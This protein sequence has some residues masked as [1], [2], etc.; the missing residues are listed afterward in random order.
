MTTS[1]VDP[2]GDGRAP[3][4]ENALVRRLAAQG[5]LVATGQ[6]FDIQLLL[7]PQDPPSRA[8]AAAGAPPGDP[9]M[10][11]AQRFAPTQ[12]QVDQVVAY[13]KQNGFTRIDVDASHFSVRAQGTADNI[14]RAFHV[15]IKTFTYQERR[16]FVNDRTVQVPAYLGALVGSVLGLQNLY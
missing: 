13:L 9:R 1:P 14:A 15:S 8:G 7:K 12:V 10:R 3:N 2:P 4:G 6:L 16:V 5:M 11:A